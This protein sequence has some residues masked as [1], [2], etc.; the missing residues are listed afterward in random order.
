MCLITQHVNK[1]FDVV[2]FFTQRRKGAKAQ[3]NKFVG[4]LT[5]CNQNLE[6]LSSAIFYSNTLSTKTDDSRQN[7]SPYTGFSAGRFYI[8]A[9]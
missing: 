9:A 7:K 3:R 4:A 6:Y 5:G 1:W 8:P 2:F